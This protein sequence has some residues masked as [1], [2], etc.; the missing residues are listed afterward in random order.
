MNRLLRLTTGLALLASPL[1]AAPH[2]TPLGPYG[3]FVS[4]LTVDP[5]SPQGLYATSRF[6]GSFKSLDGGATWNQIHIGPVS[7]NVAVDPA[8]PTTLYQSFNFNQLLKSTDGG[9]T[10]HLSSRG[11]VQTSIEVIAVDPAQHTRVYLGGESLWRSLDGGA[12]WQRAR[13]GLPKGFAG[14]IL[15]LAVAPSPPGS[16]YA[17]TGAGVFKSLDGGGSWQPARQGMPA[18]P[19]PTLAIAPANP[20]ILWAGVNATVFRSTDGGASWSATAGQPVGLVTSLA[21]DPGDP[22][23]ATVGT[24]DH[25]V[26]RTTDAGAHWTPAGP[27][28]NAEVPAVAATATTLYAGV[29][30]DFRDPGGVLASSDGGVTWQP[31]NT[32]LL[33]LTAYDLAIDPRHPEALW[34]ATGVTGLYHSIVGGREWDLSAQPPAP[35]FDPLSPPSIFSVAVSADGARLYTV[36][37]LELWASD[38]DGGD[39]TAFL[40]AGRLPPFLLISSV[41]T[42]PVDASTLYARS[43]RTI[44]ASHDSGAHWNT[45][46]SPGFG[47]AIADVALASSA[48]ATLYVLGSNSGG[49]GGCGPV[50]GI[51]RSTNGGASWTKTNVGLKGSIDS[52]AV[53]PLDA[54]TVYAQTSRG[55]SKSTDGGATWFRAGKATSGDLVFATG[56]GTLWEARG[57]QVFASHDGGASWQSTGG[58]QA[59]ILR[60]IA[61]PT[62]PDRLFAATSGGVWVLQ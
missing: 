46:P 26:Y 50:A 49:P 14:R 48:P 8:Q 28:A 56:G 10:W 45:L 59:V 20:Q 53:D 43:S 39:W 55:L 16:L 35:P 21:V 41:R 12:S 17:A 3:G 38:D 42:H 22:S 24:F 60:L 47:C 58:P 40:I 23:T 27:R 57:T 52:V 54:R 6:Q 1:A 36:F 15:A 4:T 31:R 29:V 19:V 30:P 44:F 62:R 13:Q 5:S 25:G 32:G 7:G 51:V 2:W 11:L 9:A 33:A 34:A 37:N 61:D 18:G